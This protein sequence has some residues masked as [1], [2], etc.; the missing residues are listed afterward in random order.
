MKTS[1]RIL[2]VEDDQQDAELILGALAAERLAGHVAIVRDGV[3]ALEY[4]QRRGPFAA[5]PDGNPAV[6][7]LDIKMP[8]LNGLEVLERMRADP[9][10]RL[11]PVVILTGSREE[12]DLA[13]AYRLGANAYV[14]KPVDFAQLVGVV[15]QLGAFWVWIN[16]SP[17]A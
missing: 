1:K 11:V 5:R 4:L 16:E 2:L 15:R 10:L 13:S 9:Q 8:R 7:L 12:H 6:V 14:V 17:Y 3:E